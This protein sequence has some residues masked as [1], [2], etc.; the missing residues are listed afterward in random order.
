MSALVRPACAARA[1]HPLI[2]SRFTS[3]IIRVPV[4]MAKRNRMDYFPGRA[5]EIG[6]AESM[7][8]YAR[9]RGLWRASLP[10]PSPAGLAG[11]FRRCRDADPSDH[12]SANGRYPA[13][14]AWVTGPAADTC[15]GSVTNY[16]SV[17]VLRPFS[18]LKPQDTRVSQI[19]RCCRRLCSTPYASLRVRAAAFTAAAAAAVPARCRRSARSSDRGSPPRSM[20]SIG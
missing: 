8:C 6:S 16:P 19:G 2:I 13:T 1:T 3:Q 14:G 12:I 9:F 4:P 18:R 15:C 7:R 11:A 17:G 10:G 20:P 5:G